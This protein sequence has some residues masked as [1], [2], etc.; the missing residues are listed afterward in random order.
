MKVTISPEQLRRLGDVRRDLPRL[1]VRDCAKA[2]YGYVVPRR[3]TNSKTQTL[4]VAKFLVAFLF[5]TFVTS[6]QKQLVTAKHKGIGAVRS[7]QRCRSHVFNINAETVGK[8]PCGR[9]RNT[10]GT[11]PS[12]V[13]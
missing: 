7:D 11:P 9:S 5:C 2:R 4:E 6:L 10:N 12:V 13:S 8:P 1:V 3:S